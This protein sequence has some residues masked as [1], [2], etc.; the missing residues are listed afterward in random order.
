MSAQQGLHPTR[1]ELSVTEEHHVTVVEAH[2][3]CLFEC[4]Y[5]TRDLGRH[6]YHALAPVY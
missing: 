6:R 1:H 2:R 4:R 3:K 5:M